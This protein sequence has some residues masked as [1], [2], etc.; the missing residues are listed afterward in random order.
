MEDAVDLGLKL[1]SDR[2]S[3]ARKFRKR[4]ERNQRKQEILGFGLD[5]FN[6]HLANKADSYMEN[7]E[8]YAA[9]ANQQRN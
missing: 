2:E 5:L 3:Q 8:V 9:R 4:E 6:Q 7:E 1:L